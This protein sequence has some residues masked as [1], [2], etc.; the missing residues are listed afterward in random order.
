MLS[1]IIEIKLFILAE[2]ASRHLMQQVIPSVCINF[3]SR[4]KVAMTP[5]ASRQTTFSNFFYCN[6][7]FSH[8]MHLFSAPTFRGKMHIYYAQLLFSFSFFQWFRE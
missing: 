4:L 7:I 5:T 2:A 8:T 3:E 6:I 1:E